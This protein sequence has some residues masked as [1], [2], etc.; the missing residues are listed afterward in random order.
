MLPEAGRSYS[1][2]AHRLF[3]QFVRLRRRLQ[4]SC[5]DYIV[6]I[7][8]FSI[9]SCRAISLCS[10]ILKT[11]PP[12][13]H[14]QQFLM[15]IALVIIDVIGVKEA[16]RLDI[17]LTL[18][19]LGHSQFLIMSHQVLPAAT[20]APHLLI[21]QLNLWKDRPFYDKYVYARLDR[22]HC[23]H[24]HRNQSSNVAEEPGEPRIV[25]Y[26]MPSTW[27][28]VTV[29]IIYIGMSL[30]ASRTIHLNSDELHVDSSGTVS[31]RRSRSNHAGWRRRTCSSGIQLPT[32]LSL[33]FQTIRHAHA[34]AGSAEARPPSTVYARDGVEFRRFL[35]EAQ[36][37]RG[38]VEDP[39]QGVTSSVPDGLR[40]ASQL[41]LEYS[42]SVL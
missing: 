31:W 35:Q 2:F 27:C 15:I 36:L 18:L 32:P 26:H 16:A 22:H 25:T 14:R 6:T 34:H 28:I 42:V 23:V 29:I 4:R 39:L 3:N 12:R 37:G 20:L 5:Y 13:L 33:Q 38:L 8:I 41:S 11:W 1:S 9:S 30:L 21:N 10:G 19:D 7:A 40:I 17:V 24:Q